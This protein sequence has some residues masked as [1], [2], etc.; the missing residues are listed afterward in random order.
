M[1][2]AAHRSAF[3]QVTYQYAVRCNS[4]CIATRPAN[5]NTGTDKGFERISS[6]SLT[7]SRTT[8]TVTRS[9]APISSTHMAHSCTPP[10]ANAPNANS[11][12]IPAATASFRSRATC[13][14]GSTASISM[15]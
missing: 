7:S 2:Y 12:Q 1:A 5:R 10:N 3:C 9:A 11:R 14:R 13:P 8:H 6:R 4:N 15:R